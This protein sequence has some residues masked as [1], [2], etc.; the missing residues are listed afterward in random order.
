MAVNTEQKGNGMKAAHR[1]PANLCRRMLRE[2][3]GLH[4]RA[5]CF[6]IKHYVDLGNRVRACAG[7]DS[8]SLPLF[9]LALQLY[10]A[11]PTTVKCNRNAFACMLMLM[12]A[13]PTSGRR[14]LRTSTVWSGE[15]QRGQWESGTSGSH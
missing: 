4:Y 14:F 9:L 11:I 13:D 8:E 7:D 6:E 2:A 5:V 10:D 15:I 1:I 3:M 12:P